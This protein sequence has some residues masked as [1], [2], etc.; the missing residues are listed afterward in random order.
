M[1]PLFSVRSHPNSCNKLVGTWLGITRGGRLAALTNIREANP[2]AAI[3]PGSRGAIVSSFLMS[4]DLE[5][6]TWLECF[7]RNEF[8]SSAYPKPDQVG[9]FSMLCGKFIRS[10]ENKVKV[11][12]LSVVS[13][14]A[15]DEPTTPARNLTAIDP[16]EC[17]SHGLSNSAFAN[18]WPKVLNGKSLLD[19]LVEDICQNNMDEQEILTK[20]FDILSHDSVTTGTGWR[21]S[22][23]KLD[24]LKFSIFIP[25]FKVN[26]ESN[27]TES[28]SNEKF[29]ACGQPNSSHLYSHYGTQKQTVII[30]HDTGKVRYIEKT[31]F[32]WLQGGSVNNNIVDLSFDLDI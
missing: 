10:P 23:N 4:L 24:L 22:N 5:C 32:D 1:Y 16:A 30:V 26:E 13:N 21:A 18:S 2:A 29:S 12:I 6:E 15:D 28:Q 20:A 9:G 7:K 3:G 19:Q 8:P 27:L 31:L 11:S 14:R 17:K 25:L